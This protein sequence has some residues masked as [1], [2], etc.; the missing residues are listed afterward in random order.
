MLPTK[1]ISPFLKFPESFLRGLGKLYTDYFRRSKPTMPKDLST[2][3]LNLQSHEVFLGLS[4][5]E[6]ARFRVHIASENVGVIV[7]GRVSEKSRLK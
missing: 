5:V 2:I 4:K 6:V 7:H 1:P 3:S